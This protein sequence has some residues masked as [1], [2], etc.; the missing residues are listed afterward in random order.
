MK[1]LPVLFIFDLDSTLIGDGTPLDDYMELVSFIKSGVSSKKIAVTNQKLPTP[2]QI[3]NSIPHE[4]YRPGLGEMFAKIKAMFPTAEFFI[5]SA[6]TKPYVEYNVKYLEKR[7][8][9]T[10]NRPIFARDT[11]II[12]ETNRYKKSIK[13]V[14]PRIFKA[15]QRKYPA[16]KDQSNQN[17]VETN[18]TIYIDDNDVVWDKTTNN[19]KW[20]KCPEYTYMPVFDYRQH[21][22]KEILTHPLVIEDMKTK[23]V[24]FPEILH[25]D[26]SERDL[27]YHAYMA[28]QNSYALRINIDALKDTFF[29]RF[30]K[31]LQKRKIHMLKNPF[32]NKQLDKIRSALSK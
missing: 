26:E 9:I 27:M 2:K 21:I 24:G 13:S 18:R 32:S 11:C 4:Y 15:L 10:F 7:F 3:A 16:L 5:Y 17:N 19:N 25:V 1:D 12:D 22:S 8:G 28:N 6:G 23:N 30:T 29:Q 20:I 31:T 14:Y